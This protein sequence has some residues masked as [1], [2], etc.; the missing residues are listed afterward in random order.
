M[1]IRDFFTQEPTPEILEL[2]KKQVVQS[3]RELTDAIV[4]LDRAH[5]EVETV[6]KGELQ[7]KANEVQVGGTHYKQMKIQPWDAID[8]WGL[9]YADGNA[10]KYLARWRYKGGLQDLRKAQHYITK[11]IEMEKDRLI[12]AGQ[13]IPT[14]SAPDKKSPPPDTQTLDAVELSPDAEKVE[15]EITDMAERLSKPKPVQMKQR[16]PADKNKAKT[17]A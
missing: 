7:M 14:P 3:R 1:S 10:L 16:T 2:N 12:A 8:D 9:G 13:P 17:K 15:K 5:H 11:Q 4:R 6:D